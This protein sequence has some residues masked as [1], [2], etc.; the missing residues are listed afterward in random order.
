MRDK[1]IAY[2]LA[3]F[4]LVVNTLLPEYIY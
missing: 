1:K 3:L 2:R 4:C